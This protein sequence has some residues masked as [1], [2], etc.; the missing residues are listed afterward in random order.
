MTETV[1]ETPSA[2]AAAP[3]PAP[4][5]A[6]ATAAP[7]APAQR[8]LAPAVMLGLAGVVLL[9]ALGF[10]ALQKPDAPDAPPAPAPQV[11]LPPDHTATIEALERRLAGLEARPAPSMPDIAP[12]AARVTQIEGLQGRLDRL[13]ERL[14]AAVAATRSV[15]AA[16]AQRAEAL[17]GRLEA[18]LTEAQSRLEGRLSTL[19]RGV[20]EALA[21]Q[22]SASRTA[23]TALET[24]ARTLT[25][26]VG[27]ATALEAGRPLGPHLAALG[28]QPEALSRFAATGAPTEARLRLEFEEAARAARAAQDATPRGSLAES[29]LARLGGLVTIRR[30]EQV[31]WGEETEAHLE[32]AR[33]A[34]AA[35]EID[36]TLAALEPLHPAAKEAMAPWIA[37]ARQLQEARAAISSLLAG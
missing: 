7:A 21:R 17:R 31:V 8:A 1:S 13:G 4:T 28:S 37:R 3:A 15:E 2:Q 36:A 11:A 25:A 16:D 12:L 9:A 35:G 6:P 5:P 20:N 18:G 10:L 32:R 26:V 24:R 23:L 19:E 30:G 14:D 33:R 22:E 34:L 27:V 29:A